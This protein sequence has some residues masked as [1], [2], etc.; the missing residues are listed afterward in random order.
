MF[1]SNNKNSLFPPNNLKINVSDED[2]LIHQLAQEKFRREL[3][4]ENYQD[5]LLK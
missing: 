4:K 5:M 3:C 1:I 2:I